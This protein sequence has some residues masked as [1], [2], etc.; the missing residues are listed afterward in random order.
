MATTNKDTTQLGTAEAGSASLTPEQAANQTLLGEIAS[1]APDDP[2]VG[3]RILG[4]YAKYAKTLGRQDLLKNVT[5]VLKKAQDGKIDLRKQFA[6][7]A[8]EIIKT[9]KIKDIEAQTAD[10]N[11]YIQAQYGQQSEVGKHRLSQV[12]EGLGG[13]TSVLK[14][15]GMIGG[16][17]C[18][19]PGMEE[20]GKRWVEEVKAESLALAGM[21]PDTSKNVKRSADRA[22]I[23]A[24]ASDIT[25][26]LDRTLAILGPGQVAAEAGA[27]VSQMDATSSDTTFGAASPQPAG[28][29]SAKPAAPSTEAHKTKPVICDSV[30]GASLPIC[31]LNMK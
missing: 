13:L 4:A 28:K 11:A 16:F 6:G 14:I 7:I 27:A 17:L 19:I 18:M 22:N 26:S 5:E 30:A 25:T 10:Y 15:K 29:S 24:N 23:T 3:E 31:A 1:I 12:H 8:P 9:A 2:K 21:L 20:T